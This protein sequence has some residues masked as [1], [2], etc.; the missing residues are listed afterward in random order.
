MRA[1]VLFVNGR[2][3]SEPYTRHIDPASDPSAEGMMWQRDHLV[4]G[5]TD[6]GEYRPSR[7]RWGPLVV[8]RGRYF[9]LGDNRDN[10]YDSRYVGL[11]ADADIT[12]RPDWIYLSWD[13]ERGAMRW[14]R[15]GSGIR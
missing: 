4:T 13:S 11:I 3:Q 15:I 8:P 10:S 7:D 5:R 1:K 9:L 2:A 12:G 14:G 6:P